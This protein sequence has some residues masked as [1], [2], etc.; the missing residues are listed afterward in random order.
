MINNTTA[1]LRGA[2]S[3]GNARNSG[4][5]GTGSLVG[6]HYDS[7]EESHSDNSV[8]ELKQPPVRT[9]STPSS[10]SRKKTK[11]TAASSKSVGTGVAAIVDGDDSDGTT[12][13]F[14]M[15]FL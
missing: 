2:G 7:Q 4:R 10:R 13:L 8:Q 5:G 15:N 1:A 14:I 9:S 12:L 3:S 6:E 11:A